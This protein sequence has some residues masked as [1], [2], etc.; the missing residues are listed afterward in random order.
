M[1]SRLLSVVNY[2]DLFELPIREEIPLSDLNGDVENE[3]KELCLGCKHLEQAD[4]VSLGDAVTLTMKSA[5]KNITAQACS[6]QLGRTCS[7]RS[8]K[9]PCR[10]KGL[11]PCMTPR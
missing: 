2:T 5:A 6:W 3:L 11:A 9:R 1:K 8:R 10:A 4:T 7:A